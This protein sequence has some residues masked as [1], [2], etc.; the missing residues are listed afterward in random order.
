MKDEKE[1]GALLTCSLKALKS[2][3]DEFISRDEEI[4]DN[5]YLSAES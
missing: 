3:I 2:V 4:N 1:Y 5:G